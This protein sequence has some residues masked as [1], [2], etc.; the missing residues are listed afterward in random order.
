MSNYVIFVDTAGSPYISHSG[1]KGQKWGVRRFQNEDGT[2]TNAGK[3]R[4][5][6]PRETIRTAKKDAKEY[7]RAKMYYGE[8]AGNRRKLIKATVNARSK[9][10]VYKAEFEKA[11]AEQDMAKHASKARTERRINNTVS[12]TKK[13]ARGIINLVMR[14]GAAVS[15]TAAALYYA[16]R[17][18]GINDRIA[19]FVSEK[20]S[21]LK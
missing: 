5:R 4:Y 3:E 7:A 9:D 11:L 16:G 2:L 17:Y 10:P 20:V 15:A 13:T 12:G 6:V 19:K 18:T 14:N 1:I 8:G 21:N